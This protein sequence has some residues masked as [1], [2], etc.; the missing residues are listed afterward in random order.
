MEK[1]I[2]EREL[3]E[4]AKYCEYNGFIKATYVC[5]R[6]QLN[7]EYITN[8]LTCICTCADDKNVYLFK[9]NAII[10]LATVIEGELY[11][12]KTIFIDN[13]TVL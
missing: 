6:Y 9:A 8:I 2:I 12:N 1:E 5:L 10:I 3:D 11:L 13:L 7:I 4:L